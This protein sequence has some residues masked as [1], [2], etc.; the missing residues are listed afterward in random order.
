MVSM[1]SG[2]PIRAQPSLRVSG[3]HS[4]IRAQ[5]SLRVSGK[6]SH[7]S[8]PRWTLLLLPFLH[9]YVASQ[10]AFHSTLKGKQL[11][12]SQTQGKIHFRSLFSSKFVI[13]WHC[14]P[15]HYNQQNIQMASAAACLNAEQFWW[16][17]YSIRHGMTYILGLGPCAVPLKR[18]I[19]IKQV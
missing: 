18:W 6:H 11:G 2:K 19:S 16:W 8:H 4:H 14:L 3:K 15:P 17:R 1:L 13:H 10:Q 5:P 12:H 7:S 9:S